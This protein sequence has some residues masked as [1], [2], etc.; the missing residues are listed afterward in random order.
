MPYFKHEDIYPYTVQRYSLLRWYDFAFQ[1]DLNSIILQSKMVQKG[2]I[3]C[4]HIL[5]NT[6]HTQFIDY[7]IKISGC[8]KYFQLFEHHVLLLCNRLL[9]FSINHI[10]SILL[11]NTKYCTRVWGVDYY[12]TK[13]RLFREYEVYILYYIVGMCMQRGNRAN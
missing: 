9:V 1:V 12:F 5:P 10:L 6:A 2:W 13:L 4:T 11:C 3:Y 8:A 7:T